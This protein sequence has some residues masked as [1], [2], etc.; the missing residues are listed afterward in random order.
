[1]SAVTFARDEADKRADSQPRDR[2]HLLQRMWRQLRRVQR[3]R[4]QRVINNYAWLV[5][6]L[7]DGPR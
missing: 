5:R 2:P 4:A 7:K 3:I 6:D 1:M